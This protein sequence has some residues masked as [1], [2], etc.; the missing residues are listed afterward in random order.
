MCRV[1]LIAFASASAP[2]F[3]AFGQDIP[4]QIARL[5]PPSKGDQALV[6]GK[7]VLTLTVGEMVQG[8]LS[9]PW[10]VDQSKIGT[11]KDR[12]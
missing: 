3:G 2:A 9:A 11:R 6:D 7:A 10:R 12:S 1:G 5:G 8:R 4:G